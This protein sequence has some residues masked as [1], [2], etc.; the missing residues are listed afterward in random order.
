MR[1]I[2]DLK[3]KTDSETKTKKLDHTGIAAL[4]TAYVSHTR[5]NFRDFTPSLA[6]L[7]E[8]FVKFKIL[9]L[10]QLNFSNKVI[11]QNPNDTTIPERTPY[12]RITENGELDVSDLKTKNKNPNLSL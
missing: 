8:E 12:L 4:T 3:D 7:A 11:T 1:D 5:D 9:E 10:A 2:I 6:A